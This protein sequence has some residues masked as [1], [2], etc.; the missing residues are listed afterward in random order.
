MTNI[1]T[2]TEIKEYL[3]LEHD[4][5]DNLLL[6]AAQAAIDIIQKYTGLSLYLEQKTLYIPSLCSCKIALPFT[7]VTEIKEIKI[8][9]RSIKEYNLSYETITLPLWAMGQK[10]EIIYEIGYRECPADLKMIILAYIANIY[11]RNYDLAM[12]DVILRSL[13]SY[14]HYRIGG[15]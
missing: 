10:I 4:K 11:E 2:L 14:R 3:R 13:S 15:K 9:H 7:P 8:N 1:I 5:E 12:P 6:S